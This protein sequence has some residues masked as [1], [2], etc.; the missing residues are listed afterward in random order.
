MLSFMREQGGESLPGEHG[1]GV[2]QQQ[3]AAPEKESQEFLTVAATTHNVRRSTILV[4][5]LVAVGLA[6]LGYMIRKSRPQ[7]A[8]GE[9]AKE[10]QNEIEVAISRL[11]GVSSEMVSRM[12]EIVNKFYEFSDVSQVGVGELVKNPFETESFMGAIKEEVSSSQDSAARAAL[13]RR[14]RLR[15]RAKSLK[16]LSVMRS[17]DGNACMIN[18]RILHQGDTIEGLVITEIGGDSVLL[19]WQPEG[20]VSAAETEDLTIMLKLA[21]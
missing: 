4:V 21:Q 16:L 15:Q 14:E 12:D 6:G 11:T 2:S 7:A 3:G 5:V 1:A 9:A 10:E 19:T 18:D 8:Y 13:I 20:A 17:E